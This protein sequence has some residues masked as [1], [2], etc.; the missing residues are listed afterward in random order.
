MR[1]TVKILV[2]LILLLFS[3]KQQNKF[4]KALEQEKIITKNISSFN[5]FFNEKESSRLNN[6]IAD[7]Y[8]RYMNGIEVAS[9]I[10]EFKASTKV[11]FNGFPD[12]K[13]ENQYKMIKGNHAFVHWELTG[14]NTGTYGETPAT[15]KKVKISGLS[16]QYFNEDG[17]MYQEDVYFNEL[18]LLQQLGYI[19][20][21]PVV[22]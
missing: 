13:I 6:I 19:F 9:N 21:E 5:L 18:N 1:A 11:I 2:I 10:E 12:L 17:K 14:S 4:T 8:V 15:G 16:H 3:C 22:D 20:I 7:D